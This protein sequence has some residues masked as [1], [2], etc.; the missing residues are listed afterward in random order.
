MCNYYN[1]IYEI[2]AYGVRWVKRQARGTIYLNPGMIGT[3]R[4]K[5]GKG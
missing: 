3:M 5:G 1:I 4:K 2:E